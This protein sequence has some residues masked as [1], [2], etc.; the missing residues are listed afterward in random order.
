VKD[1]NLQQHVHGI[2]IRIKV[3]QKVWA[4]HI[5]MLK[6]KDKRKKLKVAREI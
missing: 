6:N 3:F 2:P 4:Y 1:V 5:L